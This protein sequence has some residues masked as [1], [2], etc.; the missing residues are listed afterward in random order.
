VRE[1]CLIQPIVLDLAPDARVEDFFLACG[2][3]G[4]LE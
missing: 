2:V 4:E 3:D 1:V